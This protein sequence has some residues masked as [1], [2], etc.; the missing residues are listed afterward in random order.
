M[1]VCSTCGG[2]QFYTNDGFY[3]CSR[4]QTQLE[5]DQEFIFE[6]GTVSQVKKIRDQKKDTSKTEV[7]H[8]TSWEVYN[9][10]LKFLVDRL[11][12]L[13]ASKDLK[14]TVLNLWVTYLTRLEIASRSNT[15]HVNLAT[16]KRDIKVLGGKIGK[17]SENRRNSS[18]FA[19]NY[20]PK[21]RN[22]KKNRLKMPDD[23]VGE[24]SHESSKVRKGHFTK[25][26]R[27]VAVT[28]YSQSQEMMQ[29][30]S[31][32]L[33]QT[34]TLD[35]I[36]DTTSDNSPRILMNKKSRFDWQILRKVMSGRKR[37]EKRKIMKRVIDSQSKSSQNVTFSSVWALLQL[38]MILSC[39]KAT[40][41]D[42]I[43][44]NLE[45][46]LSH[47]QVIEL[48]PSEILGG[49]LNVLLPNRRLNSTMLRLTMARIANYISIAQFPPPDFNELISRYMTELNLPEK[50]MKRVR[51][52]FSLC[53]PK[54][55]FNNKDLAFHCESITMAYIIVVL[56][57]FFGLNGR[58]EFNLSKLSNHL[59]SLTG[60]EG[61][62]Y[63]SWTEWTRFIECRKY[64]VADYHYPTRITHLSKQAF[65]QSDKNSYLNY[66]R[67]KKI[68]NFKKSDTTEWEKYV[69]QTV[70]ELGD[71]NSKHSPE[72]APSLTPLSTYA[73]SLLDD[74]DCHLSAQVTHLL[75]DDFSQ[76]HLILPDKYARLG[77]AYKVSINVNRASLR[78]KTISNF[79]S[80]IDDPKSYSFEN[81]N[82][83]ALIIDDR[84]SNLVHESFGDKTM[85]T[86][87][88][89]CAA[90]PRTP[91]SSLSKKRKRRSSFSMHEIDVS[92]IAENLL[93]KRLSEVSMNRNGIDAMF[94]CA[95]NSDENSKNVSFT[96]DNPYA[97]YW[98][99]HFKDSITKED[100][101]NLSKRLF[102]VTFY[103]LIHECSN[104]INVSAI[105][106][107]SY[108]LKVEKN[109]H[110]LLNLAK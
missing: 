43:R 39:Q 72:F 91:K 5:G 101:G 33:S 92:K 23:T 12:E 64:V 106:L 44:W 8:L 107:Y 98:V 71:S 49:Y 104:M 36:G 20:S 34:Q 22:L 26:K 53:K 68:V 93:K 58:T 75:R 3:F 47:R 27:K 45:G 63:F 50:L 11:I 90:S 79:D 48:L 80:M 10:T 60:P 59:N 29:E 16:K 31:Q 69:T 4:C 81:R 70:E 7:E 78:P 88:K 19:S 110:S 74:P 103:W 28:E 77:K 52:L 57:L 14:R 9:Y 37:A 86:P 21:K 1:G 76:Q 96:V 82:V 6:Q 66:I 25:F 85:I 62:K 38:G 87:E 2:T 56:K 18:F 17:K 105:D 73:N 55:F 30:S 102:P 15:I 41:N 35:S 95:N 65:V 67:Q 97:H 109:A 94:S 13:G 51:I 32:L 89:R 99:I 100:F 83:E 61:K 46:H 84:E 40:L 108:I 54:L 42:I 24:L